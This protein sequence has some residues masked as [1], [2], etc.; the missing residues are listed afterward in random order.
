[1]PEVRVTFDRDLNDDARKRIRNALDE[2]P[3]PQEHAPALQHIVDASGS[4]MTMGA[5][6]ASRAH[7][8]VF[9]CCFG[10]MD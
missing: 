10:V 4:E 7:D 2:L 1:M 5:G 8:R 9:F 6:P 3:C